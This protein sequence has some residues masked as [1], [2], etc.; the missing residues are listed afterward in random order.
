MYQIRIEMPQNANYEKRNAP[1][2]TKYEHENYETH[3]TT[4][5][6]TE[7]QIRD[8]PRAIIIISHCF[9]DA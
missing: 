2:G 7:C 8:K 6:S 4:K 5:K 9:P 3:N 1:N